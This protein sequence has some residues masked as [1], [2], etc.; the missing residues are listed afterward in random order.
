MW[1][2]LTAQPL[3][4]RGILH[5]ILDGEFGTRIDTTSR[6][7][8]SYNPELPSSRAI[9]FVSTGP[10]RIVWN[11]GTE[12]PRSPNYAPMSDIRNSLGHLT[13]TPGRSE[14]ET[15]LAADDAPTIAPALMG[16]TPM[17]HR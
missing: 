9:C 10:L 7:A 4:G 12:S 5:V 13:V 6:I 11:T 15:C 8:M 16:D 17:T 3:T 14:W 2:T 1:G